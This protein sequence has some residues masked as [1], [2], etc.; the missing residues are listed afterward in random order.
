METTQH[1]LLEKDLSED[2]LPWLTLD[3]ALCLDPVVQVSCKQ[4]CIY[5]PKLIMGI[6]GKTAFLF[7]A[8]SKTSLS[9]CCCFVLI[10]LKTKLFHPIQDFVSI[11]WPLPT[12]ALPLSGFLCCHHTN[13]AK[14]SLMQ[15]LRL[16]IPST[17]TA[18]TLSLSMGASS[19]LP[20]LTKLFLNTCSNAALPQSPL[21]APQQSSSLRNSARQLYQEYSILFELMNEWVRFFFKSFKTK[22][23]KFS[24]RRI[25]NGERGQALSPISP[26]SDLSRISRSGLWIKT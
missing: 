6:L 5:F 17:W 16:T 4:K 7:S 3:R 12:S 1:W 25:R 14:A 13:P 15:G 20:V 23:Y 24:R 2:E 10:V 19:G 9:C 21:T 22:Y 8:F 18:P 26:K 11:T